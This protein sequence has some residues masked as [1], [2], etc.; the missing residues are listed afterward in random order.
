VQQP[1][2]LESFETAIPA[3]WT[4]A[5]NGSV[6]WQTY[7][8]AA[9]HG[10]VSV[11]VQ[12]ETLQANQATWL[13]T[14]S[15]DLAAD[16]SS[17]FT[18]MYAYA[19]YDST[20][21]DDFIVQATTDCG[22]TWM[23]IFQPTTSVLAFGSGGVSSVPFIPLPSQWKFYDLSAHPKF[24]LLRPYSNVRFRFYFKQ[25]QGAASGGNRI[26]LDQV[27]FYS[28]VSTNQETA[29]LHPRVFPSPNDGRFTVSFRTTAPQTIKYSIE[30][31]DGR[32]I[33]AGE[34]GHFGAGNHEAEI[35]DTRHIPAG[36]Y[37]LRLGD[38]TYSGRTRMIIDR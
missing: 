3:D 5:G 17:K 26:F 30:S 20:H 24:T 37:L 28:V 1:N 23:D 15:Y 8:G 29:P 31:V 14:P 11:Y 25:D 6:T 13:E 27:N 32:P 35:S 18:F 2:I 7:P 36:V 10:S 21:N 4:S 22:D 19:R 12:G 38:S 33:A 9:S 34:I 16:P